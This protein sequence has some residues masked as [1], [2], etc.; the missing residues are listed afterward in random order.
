MPLGE[1]TGIGPD[2]LVTPTGRP[3]RSPCRSACSA[4]CSTASAVPIDGAGPIAGARDWAV[5]R[6]APEPLSRRRVS[7]PLPLGVRVLDALLTVGEGQR[8]GIFAGSGVG[9]STLMGQIARQTEADVNVIALVGERGREVRRLPRGLAGPRRAARAPSS[10]APPATRPPG[11]PQVGVRRD[12]RRRVF[13]RPRPARA[14]HARLGDARRA[15]AARGRP[16][17]GRAA[18]AAGLSAQRV[19]AAAAAAGTHRQQRRAARSPR[20]TPCWS[21]AATWK[22]RSPTRC[23]ASSTD[24]SSCRASSRPAITGPP[25]TSCRRC[26]G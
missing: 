13:P 3:L 12:R 26:R 18:G 6:A 14:V 22:S 24:T 25:S 5:D 20:F 11:P 8:V 9:K 23:A 17:R 1:P 4:A 21:P 7:R 2:A 15:R 16:G 19:R 10:S